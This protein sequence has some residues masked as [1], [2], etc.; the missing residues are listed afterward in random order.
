[1]TVCVRM[2]HGYGIDHAPV[3]LVR[4][5]AWMRWTCC[6]P[7]FCVVEAH[8]WL[9]WLE[10]EQGEDAVRIEEEENVVE[11]VVTLAVKGTL[12]KELEIPNNL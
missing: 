6:C 12:W 4:C 7:A 8:G 11:M 3:F 9:R 10:N 1:M 2:R 5:L